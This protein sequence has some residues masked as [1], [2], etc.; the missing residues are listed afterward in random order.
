VHRR[1]QAV[2]AQRPTASSQIG[3]I[4]TLGAISTTRATI[5]P[6]RGL[7][8]LQVRVSHAPPQI[9]HQSVRRRSLA[10]VDVRPQQRAVVDR[11]LRRVPPFARRHGSRRHA[12]MLVVDTD[13][14]SGS[15]LGSRRD[16]RPVVLDAWSSSQ[17]VGARMAV[18]VAEQKSEDLHRR[19]ARIRPTEHGDKS[20]GLATTSLTAVAARSAGCRCFPR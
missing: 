16:Y 2:T 20:V 11:L 5:A 18:L 12:G 15:R 1:H 4:G 19:A 6:R 7:S 10:N 14:S 9:Q 17:L 8:S 13:Q 3:V